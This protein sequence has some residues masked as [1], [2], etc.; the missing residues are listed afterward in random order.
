MA[1]VQ[2]FTLGDRAA[3]VRAG[4]L[5]VALVVLFLLALDLAPWLAR[6]LS[7]RRGR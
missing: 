7:R 3:D 6:T 4:L 1:A 2:L 5:A